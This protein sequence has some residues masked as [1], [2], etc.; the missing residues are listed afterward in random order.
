MAYKRKRSGAYVGGRRYVARRTRFNRNVRGRIRGR[1][2]TARGAKPKFLFH[3]WVSPALPIYNTVLAGPG[4][5]FS[6][7]QCAYS[8]TTGILTN[9]STL[10][11]TEWDL[12]ACFSF[13]DIGNLAEF[14]A[15][16]DQYKLNAVLFQI[17]MINVPE[18]VDAPNSNVANY[19]NFFPTIWYAPDH[20]DNLVLTVAQLKEYE[21]VKHKVLRPNKEINI[22]LKPSTL[23][24][25][26]NST[27]VT[28]YAN[29]FKKPWL[30]CAT[31]AVPHYGLKFAIDFEGLTVQ[32]AGAAAFQFKI[33]AK[34]YFGVK[35]VR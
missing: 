4:V 7:A 20:D 34:Y 30:D 8:A 24:Q 19:G 33:Q 5:N 26:Y 27:A 17:K 11:Q 22:L 6:A 32:S 28:G 15:L 10:P 3:R 1:T 9:G 23:Q 31:P 21:R 29:N 12:S 13:N 18:T 35:N 25:V 14:T 16:F 2:R